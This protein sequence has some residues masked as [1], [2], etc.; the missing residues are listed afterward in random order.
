MVMWRARRQLPMDNDSIC[1]SKTGQV[2]QV[3]HMSFLQLGEGGWEV[4][5]AFQYTEDHHLLASSIITLT[6][7]EVLSVIKVR[8]RYTKCQ[9]GLEF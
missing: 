6:W 5:L 1:K 9:M 7:L 4:G 2:P 3:T 8:T